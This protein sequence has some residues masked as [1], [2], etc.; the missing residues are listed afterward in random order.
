M[1]QRFYDQWRVHSWAQYT[2]VYTPISY[3]YTMYILLHHLIENVLGKAVFIVWIP[4]VQ[5]CFACFDIFVLWKYFTVPIYL[6]DCNEIAIFLFCDHI[7]L[8]KVRYLKY[9]W[10]FV[11]RKICFD[12][13]IY[14]ISI[15]FTILNS[16]NLL[17][18]LFADQK[19][20][21]HF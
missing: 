17:N 6:L 1:C 21:T 20:I 4:T 12:F 3:I 10:K 2:L 18:V 16:I 15:F 7:N 5:K 14:C 19:F 11:F 9:K 8:W 13:I